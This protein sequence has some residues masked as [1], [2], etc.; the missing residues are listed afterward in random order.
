MAMNLFATDKKPVKGLL[1]MEWVI[2]AYTVLT[3]VLMLLMYTRLHN[4]ASMLQL[5]FQA[6]AIMLA[7]WGVYR[8]VPCRLVMLLRVCC[9][10]G[11]LGVWYPDTYEFNRLLP[12]LDHVFAQAEQSLFGFQPA[13]TFSQSWSHPVVSEL[14]ELG[15]VSYFP[16][17]AAVTVFCYFCRYEQLQR[18][19]FI[20]MGS[21]FLFYVVFI[22]LP[23]AGPQYYYPAVG[24]DQIAQGVFPNLGNYFETHQELLP[25]PGWADGLF[26]RLVVDAHAA[27]ERPTAAFPSS[28][29]G[30]TVVLLWL[31]WRLNGRW[32]FWVLVPLAVLMFFATFY[33]Q[34]HYVIDALAGLVTGTLFYWLFHLLFP[35]VS[36]K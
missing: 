34:A 15:Y 35:L 13:L 26:H 16:M 27:G 9:Q 10:M 21:F 36:R 14:L 11:L 3:L 23:V 31:A 4:P 18:T 6:V 28:H 33:I 8:L 2:L 22:F 32:L 25:T 20:I 24:F 29:V 12:N 1:P 17:I 30:I 5:R 7:T 19:I